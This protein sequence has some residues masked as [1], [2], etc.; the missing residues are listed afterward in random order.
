M[1]CDFSSQQLLRYSPTRRLAARLSCGHHDA[2]SSW[3]DA[4]SLAGRDQLG[5]V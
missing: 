1:R 3:L 5:P 2:T 4:K